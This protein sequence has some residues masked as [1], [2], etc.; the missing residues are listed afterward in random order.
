[1]T[2]EHSVTLSEV[3]LTDVWNEPLHAVSRTRDR[4]GHIDFAMVI[5]P[6]R[7]FIYYMICPF[8]CYPIAFLHLWG[9]YRCMR[10]LVFPKSYRRDRYASHVIYGVQKRV[11]DAKKKKL[12]ESAVNDAEEIQHALQV[13]DGARNHFVDDPNAM[14]VAYFVVE[15]KIMKSEAIFTGENW[16]WAFISDSCRFLT[17]AILAYLFVPS[18][19]RLSVDLRLWYQGRIRWRQ[20]RHP[21]LNFFKSYR[22]YN[23]AI[24]RINV[25][26]PP[27]K[28]KK[29]WTRRL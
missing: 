24:R 10:T 28:G 7:A 1:M 6:L 9:F 25:T 8:L 14:G 27:E 23:S 5:P 18:C 19:R 20:L 15:Q 22:E 2:R 13:T 12:H 3:L 16:A 29:P 17:P 26:K 11:Y 21:V 4:L